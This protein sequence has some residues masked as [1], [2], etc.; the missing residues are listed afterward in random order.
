MLGLHSYPVYAAA[1]IYE[2]AS[3][4][5]IPLQIRMGGAKLRLSRGK[6]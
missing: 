4:E 2:M 6:R 5:T 1:G 3:K